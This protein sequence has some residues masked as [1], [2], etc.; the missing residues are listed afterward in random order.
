VR[1]LVAD[2]NVDAAQTLAE[3]LRLEGVEVQEA[4]DGAEALAAALRW[5]PHVVFLDLGMPRLSGIDVARELRAAAPAVRPC[6]VA[7][8]GWGQE[9]DVAAARA[10]GFDEHL[11]KPADPAAVVRI[12]ALAGA[13]NAPP[14]TPRSEAA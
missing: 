7:L 9:S 11:T 3:L 8:T 1:V 5:L 12:A 6:L 10:A 4:H 13:A 14:P 2:D